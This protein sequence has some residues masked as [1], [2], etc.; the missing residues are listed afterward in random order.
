L[1][2]TSKA[3]EL[4][5]AKYEELL[6]KQE[7]Q[8]PEESLQKIETQLFQQREN[9]ARLQSAYD[10][11]WF[12]RAEK[13]KELEAAKIRRTELLKKR[14]ALQKKPGEKIDIDGSRIETK[15]SSS[16]KKLE[17]LFQNIKTELDKKRTDILRFKSIY[18]KAWFGRETKR[19]QFEEA[20]KDYVLYARKLKETH[21]D[22]KELNDYMDTV[23]K[24]LFDEWGE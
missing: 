12:G 18:D 21:K 1:T 13:L 7:K 9:I 23:E 19:K 16:E 14:N 4:I 24:A 8:S 3:R 5:G 22:L 11:A 6:T 17:T 20:K 10:K 15:E 2:Q